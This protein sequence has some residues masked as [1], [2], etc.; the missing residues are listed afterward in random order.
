MP[1]RSST[2]DETLN[3]PAALWSA[4]LSPFGLKLASMFEWAGFR[5]RWFPR[6]GRRFENIATAFRVAQARRRGGVLRHGG[7]SE[8]D[9]L[10][11]VPFLITPDQNVHYDSS[12]LADWIDDE[13]PAERGELVPRDPV[14]NFLARFIDEAFD[15][16]GLYMVHHNR[17][18]LAAANNGAGRRLAAEFS[19]LL[20]PGGARLLARRFSMRQ[21]RRLPYLFSVATEGFYADL[22]QSLTPPGRKGFP[23]THALL[24]DAWH[25]YLA[26]M[27]SLLERQPFLLGAR[28]TLA[29]ASAY[30]QLSMN[31][32]DA[33]AVAVLEKCA[34]RTHRWLCS[35]RDGGHCAAQGELEAT[36]ALRPLLEVISETFVPLMRQNERAYEAALARGETLFNEA[37]FD[38]NRALYDG[39]LRGKPFRHVVKT[40]QVRT[41]R[42]LRSRWTLLDSE[43]RQALERSLPG[44]EDVFT[45]Q[46]L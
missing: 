22:P 15:E 37:A 30:G 42:D 21:V 23:G 1:P 40:F 36:E 24:E 44:L 27:E 7:R 33:G 5:Y 39:E 14:L 41:W 43:E 17:W 34:P 8:L 4:E 25:Q 46:P 32:T 29:D 45:S 28:F 2:S 35:I 18:V 3:S 16:F 9:E 38:R 19:N 31:L 26:A 10:P 20:P 6:Q 11:T 13:H 12:A